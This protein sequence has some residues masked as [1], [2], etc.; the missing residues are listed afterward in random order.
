MNIIRDRIWRNI[1][2]PS[3]SEWIFFPNVLDLIRICQSTCSHRT[4]IIGLVILSI[5]PQ[6]T[7]LLCTVSV[8][9][10]VVCALSM[11]FLLVVVGFFSYATPRK[12]PF[13]SFFVK[14]LFVDDHILVPPSWNHLPDRNLTNELDVLFVFE[15][16]YIKESIW[17][18][19]DERN[20]L[21]NCRYNAHKP[22]HAAV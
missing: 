3:L 12:E 5:R 10:T 2:Q 9:C 13:C 4:H 15:P 18:I 16:N 8:R 6:Q 7:W 19:R 21:T 11:Y 22:P 20:L 17:H 14:Y 1:N